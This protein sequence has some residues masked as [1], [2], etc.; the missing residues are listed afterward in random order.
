MT[1]LIDNQ[2]PVAPF[3]LGHLPRPVSAV[4]GPA[5][6]HQHGPAFSFASSYGLAGTKMCRSSLMRKLP[7]RGSAGGWSVRFGLGGSPDQCDDPELNEDAHRGECRRHAGLL[8]PF[9]LADLVHR[10]RQGGDEHAERAPPGDGLPRSLSWLPRIRLR[11]SRIPV[12]T[13][14]FLLPLGTGVDRT[15]G[16]GPN[17]R[18]DSRLRS[19]AQRGWD[20]ADARAGPPKARARR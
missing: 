9:R 14:G 11:H 2:D 1:A 15:H 19:V 16:V 6:Q 3:E 10:F 8:H 17:P 12:L 7:S 20:G 4:A 5:V 13:S 18:P